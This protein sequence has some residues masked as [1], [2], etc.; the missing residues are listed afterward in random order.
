MTNTATTPLLTPDDL[1]KISALTTV[2]ERR[3]FLG[4]HKSLMQADVIAELNAA[5]LQEFRIN[6]ATALALADTAILIANILC[7]LELLAQS[8]RIKAHVLS[9]RGEY[10]SAVALYNEAEKLFE[11]AKDQEGVGRTVT[12]A[13]HPHIMIGDYDGAFARATKAQ[14]IF[15]DMGDKRRLARLEN[16]IGNIFHRQDRFQ[17]ALTHYEYAYQQLSARTETPKSYRFP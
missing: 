17:E 7:R 14:D 15:S 6:T 12:A 16:N 4:D 9:E 10:Q 3:K 8:K 13:I 11:Q 2:D 1:T 5:T